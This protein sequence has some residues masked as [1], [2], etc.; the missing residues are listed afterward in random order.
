MSICEEINFFTDDYWEEDNEE[1]TLKRRCIERRKDLGRRLNK[2]I[3]TPICHHHDCIHLPWRS[4]V[5]CK[6]EYRN[7][8]ERL[9][10]LPS[11]EYEMKRKKQTLEYA[12]RNLHSCN[13][14]KILNSF[15]HSKAYAE[16][17]YNKI[18]QYYRMDINQFG[19]KWMFNINKMLN[20]IKNANI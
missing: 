18:F 17:V 20:E 4:C 7:G 2:A 8:I 13:L 9:W 19:Y 15:N 1:S 6:S 5:W 12:N 3:N 16:H 14:Y 11:I 10:Y